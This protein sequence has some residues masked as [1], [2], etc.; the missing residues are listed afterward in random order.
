MFLVHLEFFT[1]CISNDHLLLLILNLT[2]IRLINLYVGLVK[3]PTLRYNLKK[4]KPKSI[5]LK[6]INLDVTL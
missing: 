6:S 3:N 2:N 5:H 1:G 4:S